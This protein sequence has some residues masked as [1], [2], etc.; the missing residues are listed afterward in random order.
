[1]DFEC[2]VHEDQTFETVRAGWS[3]LDEDSYHE[4][5]TVKEFLEDAFAK[6]MV[7]ERE[8]QNMRGFDGTF[9]QEGLYDMGPNI[10]KVLNQRAKYVSFECGNL[11]F[12]DSLN[13]CNMPLE[14]L[15]ATFN[16][17]ELHKR[18]F[19]YS[20]IKPEMY[21]Y[22]GPYPLAEDYHPERMT[23]KRRKEFLT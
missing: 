9:F 18:F 20:W 1:M 2:T 7:D 21:A 8:R 12:R 6:T 17:P 11:I 22:V 14:K 16:L 4:K 23:L 15:P 10:D 5:A 13:F 19:P 3:Y